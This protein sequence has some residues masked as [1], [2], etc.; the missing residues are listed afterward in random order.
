M[1]ACPPKSR[2][3]SSAGVGCAFAYDESVRFGDGRRLEGQR[4]CIKDREAR[5]DV[6]G[7]NRGPKTDMTRHQLVAAR[8]NAERHTKATG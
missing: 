7:L 1:L 5:A 3:I 8:L 4:S 6:D 2:P